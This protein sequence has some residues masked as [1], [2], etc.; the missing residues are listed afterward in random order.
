[1]KD[2]IKVVISIDVITDRSSEEVKKAVIKGIYKELDTA[3]NYIAQPKDVTINNC[4]TS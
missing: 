1:M 3:P 2:T 4:I